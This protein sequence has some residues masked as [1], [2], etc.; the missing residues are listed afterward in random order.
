MAAEYKCSGS[1]LWFLKNSQAR[2]CHD[3][4]CISRLVTSIYF[5]SVTSIQT[6]IGLDSSEIGAARYDRAEFISTQKFSVS[7]IVCRCRPTV[8][9][10]A[11][12]RTEDLD[13]QTNDIAKGEICT[14]R[15]ARTVRV[16][17]YLLWRDE[18]HQ[19]PNISTPVLCVRHSQTGRK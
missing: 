1:Q 12:A 10:N 13:N 2:R 8:E 11:P 9:D 7:I 15:D 18:T 14:G 17:I 5:I 3:G 19:Y 16:C 4:Q 6:H